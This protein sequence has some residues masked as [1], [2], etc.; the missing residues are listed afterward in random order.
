MGME[1]Q[2]VSWCPSSRLVQVC[3]TRSVRQSVGPP[4]P[5]DTSSAASLTSK[6]TMLP[7]KFMGMG[8]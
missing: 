2:R 3:S 7:P 6:V 4:R 1:R 5:S 8:M